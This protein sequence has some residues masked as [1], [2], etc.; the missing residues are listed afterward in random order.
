MLL[1]ALVVAS[2]VLE[3]ARASRGSIPPLVPPVLRRADPRPRAVQPARLDYLLIAA[4]LAVE[5]FPQPVAAAA[6]GFTVLGDALAARRPGLRAHALLH[7]EPRGLCRG[8]G[9][10]PPA[11]GGLRRR[12]RRAPVGDPPIGSVGRK[13]CRAL[14]I[15]WTTTRHDPV[16][17]ILDEAARRRLVSLVPRKSPKPS[18]TSR[19]A[20]RARSGRSRRCRPWSA[21]SSSP[22]TARPTPPPRPHV[23]NEVARVSERMG[24]WGAAERALQIAIDLRPRYADLHFRRACVLIRHQRAAGAP[25]AGCRAE[26]QPA[27]PRGPRRARAARRARRAVSANRWPRCACCRASTR[28]TTRTRFSRAF[29]VWSARTGT[30]PSRC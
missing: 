24:D 8:A 10:S 30:A 9:G 25:L 26:A 13:S 20:W 22:P 1:I 28:S 16:R 29:R 7:Q 23:L 17:R 18:S 4:L 14:P 19:C 15:P 6:L 12:V 5:I 3:L 2:I 11:V 21:G 27:L